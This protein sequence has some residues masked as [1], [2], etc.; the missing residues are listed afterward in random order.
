M[1]HSL[2]P[3][4]SVPQ[5]AANFGH[6][7]FQIAVGG[8]PKEIYETLMT[9]GFYDDGRYTMHV[10]FDD[11]GYYHA[12]HSNCPTTTLTIEPTQDLTDVLPQLREFFTT[13][14]N[15]NIALN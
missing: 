9:V 1:M 5:T 7:H 6:G 12:T 4:D 11:N 3:A 15:K 10:E 14:I 2:L 13:C 8:V